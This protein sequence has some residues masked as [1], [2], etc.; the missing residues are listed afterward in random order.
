MS[1]DRE[2]ETSNDETDTQGYDSAWANKTLDSSALRETL[3]ARIRQAAAWQQLN[4]PDGPSPAENH[5]M[6]R[7]DDIDSTLDALDTDLPALQVLADTSLNRQQAEDAAKVQQKADN[8]DQLL[9]LLKGNG[10]LKAPYNALSKPEDVCSAIQ[11]SAVI[12]DATSSSLQLAFTSNNLSDPGTCNLATTSYLFAR[13]WFTTTIHQLSNH[14]KDCR[15]RVAKLFEI[16]KSRD[17][18]IAGLKAELNDRKAIIEDMIAQR[19]N[20]TSS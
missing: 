10:Q 1:S 14:L 16:V 11:G 15:E 13:T 4:D 2:M 6:K 17:Q 19:Q 8:Y 20:T 9:E 7:L 3:P 12:L 5:E 18:E